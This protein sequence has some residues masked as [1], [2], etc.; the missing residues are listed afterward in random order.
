MPGQPTM[1][2]VARLA[3]VDSSTVS[4]ALN[5]RTATSLRPE[6]VAKVLA[7]SEQLGYRPNVLAR[8]LRTQRTH[9]VG[10]LLPDVT[11]PFFPPIIRGIEDA[12]IPTGHVLLIANTDN[13]PEREEQGLDSLVARQVD[14]V[15][16]ATSHLDVATDADRLGGIPT[17]LVNRR[18][19]ASQVPAV[20]P[21]DVKGVR[22]VVDHLH[23][24][25]HRRI[26][27]VSG[28]LDTSTGRD[29][30]D[31][32]VAACRDLGLPTDHVVHADR[33]DLPSGRRAAEVLLEAEGP[34]PT[35]VF[36]SNDLLAVGALT[37]L[38]ARGLRVPDDVSLVGYNDMPLVDLLDPALTTVRIDQYLMGRRAAEVM[39]ELLER[40]RSEGSGDGDIATVA[41]V[42]I[43][44]E[45]VVRRSTGAP[46]GT[47]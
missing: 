45:L 21:D 27:L 32:F 39:L 43:V 26:A 5:S 10:L 37:A 11:N 24:L 20:L 18:D 34:A 19:R 2:D 7:A 13:E 8:G 31:T 17:V 12:L 28:P 14:G 35:A 47:A 30:R 16:L 38:R 22:L 15:M 41:D 29:R 9:T 33:Y 1:S 44:P 42:T 25:G 23:G 3:G 40:S 46:P 4:R 36:A 6:T